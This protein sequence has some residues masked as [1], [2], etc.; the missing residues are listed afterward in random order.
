M[1]KTTLE[2]IAAFEEML[3]IM[4]NHKGNDYLRAELIG[5][6]AKLNEASDKKSAI[7]RAFMVPRR[8]GLPK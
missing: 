4:P 1:A 6:I 5:R 3:A 8:N 7:Q 2:K